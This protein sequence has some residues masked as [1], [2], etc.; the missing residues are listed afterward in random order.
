MAKSVGLEL[1]AK[2]SIPALSPTWDG[3]ERREKEM[4]HKTFEEWLGGL[5]SM[6]AQNL[7]TREDFSFC[8]TNNILDDLQSEYAEF[9]LKWNERFGIKDTIQRITQPGWYYLRVKACEGVYNE[10][11][12]RLRNP[13]NA[14]APNKLE[15]IRKD[16]EK[17]YPYQGEQAPVVARVK[18]D[19]AFGPWIA[20]LSAPINI[21]GLHIVHHNTWWTL[22]AKIGF[23]V[24]IGGP[25]TLPFQRTAR[26][27]EARPSGGHYK[28][29]AIL[30]EW[31]FAA[32]RENALKAADNALSNRAGETIASARKKVRAALA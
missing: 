4:E 8:G 25:G 1:L 18:I 14:W 19:P 32:G 9:F 26:L 3:N 13:I 16:W 30:L 7:S 22:E 11:P 10:Y 31:I 6:P 28:G 15:A 23:S 24:E 29:T 27:L 5:A 20:E 2:Y 17:T 21:G 12:D